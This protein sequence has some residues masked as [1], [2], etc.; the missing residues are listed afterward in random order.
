MNNQ[1]KSKHC[2]PLEGIVEIRTGIWKTFGRFWSIQKSTRI[3]NKSKNEA[4]AM[5]R[6]ARVHCWRVEARPR[7]GSLGLMGGTPPGTTLGE[8][9]FISALLWA[10]L[11]RS[12][13]VHRLLMTCCLGRLY[14]DSFLGEKYLH[15]RMIWALAALARA[16]VEGRPKSK[17]CN[18]LDKMRCTVHK[19]EPQTHYFIFF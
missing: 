7:E 15:N 19:A 11:F 14:R 13:F 16:L 5:P 3:C 12:Q 9:K 1:R 4:K 18:L 8:S 17:T 10:Y 2:A 6:E